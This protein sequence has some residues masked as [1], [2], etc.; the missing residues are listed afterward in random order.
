MPCQSTKGLRRGRKSSLRVQP[1][2]K[3]CT[4][5]STSVCAE[6]H[7]LYTC[8]FGFDAAKRDLR[9]QQ[10]LTDDART[11]TASQTLSGTSISQNVIFI[12]I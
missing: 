3:E 7:S 8:C 5:S 2:R 11:T 4:L 1:E 6:V 9:S 12:F 10:I